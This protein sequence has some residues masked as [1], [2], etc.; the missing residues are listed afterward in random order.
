MTG[1]LVHFRLHPAKNEAKRLENGVRLTE[2]VAKAVPTTFTGE[3][4]ET[5]VAKEEVVPFINTTTP[6]GQK[7]GELIC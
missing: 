4:K 2:K 1:R 3:G 5:K 7:K 6:K